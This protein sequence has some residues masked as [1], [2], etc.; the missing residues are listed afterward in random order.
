MAQL[1]VAEK[2]ALL[3]QH[4]DGA[5]WTRI[6]AESGVSLRTLARW[7]AKYRA[8][9]TRHGLQRSRRS[10]HA[11]RR[12]PV[13]LIEAIEALALRRPEPTAAYIHRRVSDIATG[14]GLSPPSYSSV[15]AIIGAIDP[16]LRTLAHHGDAAYRDRFELVFRRTAARPNEQWQADH[17]LLDIM[18][19]GTKGTAVRPWLT[20]VLDDYSRAVAGYTLFT[21]A[22]SAE[23]TALALHHAINTKA[24]PDWPMSGLPEVLYSDHGTDFTS[25]RLKQVCLDTHIRLIH[26]RVGVPQ[27]RGKIER[28]YGTITTELLPHP[29]GHIPHGTHGTPVTAPALTLEQLDGILE[30]FIVTAYN[31]RPHSQTHQIPVERWAESGFIPRAPAHPE[32]LDLLLLTATA[33]RKVQR[34]GIKFAATRYVSPVLAAYVGEHVTVRY[35]P[36]DVG[37]IRVYFND[38]FL[39]RAIAPELAADSVSLKELQAARSQQRR[40]LKQQLRQ[41]RSLADAL[42]A[43][44]RYVPPAPAPAEADTAEEVPPRH[45]LRLSMPPIDPTHSVLEPGDDGRKFLSGEFGELNSGAPPPR[46]GPPFQDTRE[47]RRFAEFAD[48]VRTHRHI[49]LCWGPPGVGKTL[50]ARHYSG[51]DDWDQWQSGFPDDLGPV[52]ERVLEARTAYFTPTVSATVREIDRGL[53]RAC[54]QVSYA[55][56]YAEH[57]VVDPFIHRESRSSGRTELLIIDEADRLKTTGLE[58]VRDYFDR[59]AMGVILIGMPGIEKRLARY[60]QLYSRIGFAHEYHQLAPEE[61]TAV[62]THRF[63]AGNDAADG[64]LA[65][66][67]AIATI[68]RI[69][70]GNYRLVD[71]LLAQIERVRA[72][73]NL[74]GLSPEMVDTARQALLIGH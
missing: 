38:A 74:G 26:S 15:R 45:R 27:G 24:N 18:V 54:Q 73:N 19:L 30:Q 41:R 44:T 29:P 5:P 12:I 16:G 11:G 6:A 9:P 3:C 71:R 25:E 68:V 70:G 33:P 13:E 39:C 17:T 14:R 53:P 40:N 47:H 61:L 59:H 8:D 42:P 7:S 62:L 22:P 21:G 46:A 36:R 72:V 43:D 1:S 49:G 69:T 10:D 2:I 20:I 57:G 66:A 32:D 34:D 52:P 58:Q 50:S 37:E 55:L 4:D 65:H 48:T 51:S 28:F 60:P 63:P 23:Q 67:T 64:G 31:A 56:D 35:N